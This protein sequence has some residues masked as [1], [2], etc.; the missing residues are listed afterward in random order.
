MEGKWEGV[1]VTDSNRNGSAFGLAHFERRG[2]EP[3]GSRRWPQLQAAV[4]SG[5]GFSVSAAVLMVHAKDP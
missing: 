5:L 2:P 1:E 3:S 4:W